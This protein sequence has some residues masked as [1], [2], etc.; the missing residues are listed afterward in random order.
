[1]S[2][3][4]SANYDSSLLFMALE[5]EISGRLPKED[6]DSY[7]E[8]FNDSSEEVT[9]EAEQSAISDFNDKLHIIR[10]N[11]DSTK[12]YIGVNEINKAQEC[13]QKAKDAAVKLSSVSY[14]TSKIHVY[15]DAMAI[16]RQSIAFMNSVNDGTYYKNK[17]KVTFVGGIPASTKVMAKLTKRSQK[18]MEAFQKANEKNADKKEKDKI[19]Q[20]N[21]FVTSSMWKLFSLILTEYKSYIQRYGAVSIKIKDGMMKEMM[22]ESANELDMDTHRIYIGN[23][24][25]KCTE[26][27][28]L[29]EDEAMELESAISMAF[30]EIESHMEVMTESDNSVAKDWI[31]NATSSAFSKDERTA[32]TN[33]ISFCESSLLGNDEA[34]FLLESAT[35]DMKKEYRLSTKQYND[36][37]KNYRKALRDKRYADARVAVED[38]RKMLKD[39]IKKIESIK[40]DSLTETILSSLACSLTKILVSYVLLTSSKLLFVLYAHHQY[41]VLSETKAMK[42]IKEKLEGDGVKTEDL[43]FYKSIILETLEKLYIKTNL[44]DKNIDKKKELDEKRKAKKNVNESVEEDLTMKNVEKFKAVK[45]KLY[46]ECAEGKITVADRERLIAATRS[47]YLTEETTIEMFDDVFKSID[48]LLIESANSTNDKNEN[49]FKE[50]AVAYEQEI[51]KIRKCMETTISN[52]KEYVSNEKYDMAIDSCQKLKKEI[53]DVKNFIVRTSGDKE[54]ARALVTCCSLIYLTGDSIKSLKSKVVRKT[55]IAKTAIFSA[56]TLGALYL[57]K[58]VFTKKRFEDTKEMNKFG[59]QCIGI[60]DDYIKELDL[61]IDTINLYKK[62]GLTTIKE[63]ADDTIDVSVDTIEEIIKLAKSK[64]EDGKLSED[65]SKKLDELAKE[66]QSVLDSEEDDEDDGEEEK[67]DETAE[68]SCGDKEEAKTESVETPEPEDSR[69]VCNDNKQKFDIMKKALYEKCAAGEITEE[70]REQ[71]IGSLRDKYLAE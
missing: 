28:F 57:S 40:R 6:I 68:E 18:L 17:P 37:C 51:I 44:L 29:D 36:Y 41:S 48:T 64:K 69:I 21:I 30:N 71:M 46:T 31:E 62:H 27:S 10:T 11:L 56:S 59:K 35:A 61:T 14:M 49:E 54:A 7:L 20:D 2:K 34:M 15:H 23:F 45:S 55:D 3:T 9:L 65:V 33:F 13:L 52:A 60:L 26:D 5:S 66:L 67:V 70:Q 22:K 24:I 38:M 32:I 47:T 12:R 50:K 8:L 39:S 19:C 58:K 16:C 53:N 1:M 63:S 4:L 25:E 43:D 42:N